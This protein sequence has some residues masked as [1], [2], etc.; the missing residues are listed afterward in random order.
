MM[1]AQDYGGQFPPS[2]DLALVHGDLDAAA[3][4]CPASGHTPAAGPTTRA[5]AA[6]LVGD[7]KHCSYVYTGAGLTLKT[8][9]P[10]HVLAYEHLRNH[11]RNGMNV[12]F[13]DGHV[14]WVESTAAERVVAELKAGHNPPRAARA[15]GM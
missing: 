4:I 8:A 12:L 13:G 6:R 9:T 1:Y 14:E 3:F 7:P 10:G 15:E 5:V 11:Q 2:F